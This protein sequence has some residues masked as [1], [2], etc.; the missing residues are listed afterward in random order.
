MPDPTDRYSDNV[1]GSW[2]VDDQ[3]IACGLCEEILSE[4]FVLSADADHNFVF[5]QPDTEAQLALAREAM[6]ACPVEAI[7]N[8]G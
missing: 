7:G 6:D 2:Y 8:D 3:C 5:H 4:V 1:P